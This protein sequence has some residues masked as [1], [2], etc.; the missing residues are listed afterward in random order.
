MQFTGLLDKNGKE[1]YEGDIV[2]FKGLDNV[3]QWNQLHCCL[4]LFQHGSY[5][6]E[7]CADWIDERG[8]VPE[9][10][11]SSDYEVIGNIYENENL[12]KP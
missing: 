5:V 8:K 7:M 6:S 12:L 2:L 9:E 11:M 4:G 1:I 3:I 10:W